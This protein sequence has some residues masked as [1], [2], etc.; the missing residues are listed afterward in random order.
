MANTKLVY[1]SS[2]ETAW[3]STGRVT[4]PSLILVDG[5]TTT[6]GN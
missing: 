1:G 5:G 4:T 6:S 3:N 2:T